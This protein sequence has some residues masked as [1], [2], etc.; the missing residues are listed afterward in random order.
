MNQSDVHSY[1]NSLS[2]SGKPV[3]DLKRIASLLHD[4]GDPQDRLRFIHIAGTNGKGS[5]AQ[6]LNEICIDAG[7]RTGLFTSPYIFRF[8][9]R[10]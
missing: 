4:L 2:H 9:D 5:I 7:L 1:I 6:M 8:N 10:I 3:K